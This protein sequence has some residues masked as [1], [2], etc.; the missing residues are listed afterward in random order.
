MDAER[1]D[2]LIQQVLASE[3][4][5]EFVTRTSIAMA[6]IAVKA[7]MVS[8]DSDWWHIVVGSHWVGAVRIGGPNAGSLNVFSHPVGVN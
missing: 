7:W 6:S 1:A 3:A 2:A 5:T 8:A 4:F